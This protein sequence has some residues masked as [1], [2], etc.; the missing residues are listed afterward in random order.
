MPLRGSQLSVP[1][2]RRLLAGYRALCAYLSRSGHTLKQVAK[3][4]TSLDACLEGFVNWMYETKG[5]ASL[6]V[7]K[8]AVLAVQH[9]F[10]HYRRRLQL[11]WQSVTAWEEV[12]EIRVPAPL[13]LSVLAAFVVYSRAQANV[14]QKTRQ[15]WLRFAIGLEIGFFA[16][17][18]PGEIF[19]LLVAHITLPDSWVFASRGAVLRIEAPKNRRRLSRHQFVLV[20]HGPCCSALA[21]VMQELHASEK[22]WP[23]GPAR[24]RAL[25]KEVSVRLGVAQL[26]FSPASLRAGG[27]SHLHLSGM[28]IS[29]LKFRGRWASERTLA[30]HVQLALSRQVQLSLSSATKRSITTLIRHGGAF[31]LLADGSS[32]QSPCPLPQLPAVLAA[33]GT[34]DSPAWL[35]MRPAGS[36]EGHCLQGP[37]LG[38]AR[39]LC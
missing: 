37:H 9:I 22:F 7:A 13:P 28:E 6:S 32:W 19:N 24:F 8:H 20:E 35:Q 36:T 17:L 14:R 38:P 25:F 23:W 2:K 39:T 16:L 3:R 15:Q 10:P 33:Y 18:R 31:L 4:R 1:Y 29:R 12:T 21:S 30:H 5:A 27:A 34:L 26:G 11:A